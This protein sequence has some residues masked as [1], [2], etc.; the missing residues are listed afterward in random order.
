[1]KTGLVRGRAQPNH[2]GAAESEVEVPT[3]AGPLGITNATEL[4]D[5]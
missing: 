3:D 5:P 4:D 1:M 2:S